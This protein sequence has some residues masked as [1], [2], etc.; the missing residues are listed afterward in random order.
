MSPPAADAAVPPADMTL[1]RPPAEF[2]TPQW[3]M[4][5]TTVHPPLPMTLTLT[6][7]MP[8]TPPNPAE[9]VFF[10]VSGIL[11]GWQQVFVLD[12]LATILEN[13]NCFKHSVNKNQR[14]A[15]GI[16]G[17]KPMRLEHNLPRTGKKT[18]LIKRLV[19][20]HFTNLDKFE[21]DFE[22]ASGIRNCMAKSKIKNTR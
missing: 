13:E 22:G 15:E 16:C 8:A 9:E 18:V 7:S 11:P 20:C 2:L 1:Q 14:I 4:V 19:G 10:Q 5:V 17:L 12:H 6:P 3:P 21:S